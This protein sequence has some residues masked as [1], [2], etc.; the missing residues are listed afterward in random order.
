MGKT[1]GIIAVTI[2]GVGAGAW[3][4]LGQSGLGIDPG[5]LTTPPGCQKSESLSF[6]GCFN[7]SK[8]LGFRVAGAPACLK[9]TKNDCNGDIIEIHESCRS[10]VKIGSKTI[11]TGGE[12][13]AIIIDE[14]GTPTL[15]YYGSN[16]LVS[17][18]YA[19]DRKIRLT[20]TAEG[21]TFTISYTRKKACE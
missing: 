12:T 8:M 5:D 4:I 13:D 1:M 14:T 9:I 11:P 7:K 16:R 17:D 15:G 2:I 21:K 18:T 10:E 6:G 19:Q 3:L 20:G